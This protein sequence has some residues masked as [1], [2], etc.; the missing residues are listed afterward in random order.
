MSAIPDHQ[1]SSSKPASDWA[2]IAAQ[3]PKMADT[4]GR[5]LSQAATFLAPRS[6]DVADVLLRQFARW[7][8]EHTEIRA[9]ADVGRGYIED[10][11]LWLVARPALVGWCDR[12]RVMTMQ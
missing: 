9:V 1:V 11:K 2:Q 5:Y 3:A 12:M 4:L 6:V 7:L 10:F 8:L